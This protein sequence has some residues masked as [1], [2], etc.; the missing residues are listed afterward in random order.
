M[1]EL[2]I[3]AQFAVTMYNKNKKKNSIFLKPPFPPVIKHGKWRSTIDNFPIQTLNYMGFSW[4]SQLAMF[5][6]TGR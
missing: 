4:V 6:E 1:R 5:D 3:D 2:Q